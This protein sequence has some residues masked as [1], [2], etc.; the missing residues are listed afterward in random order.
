VLLFLLNLHYCLSLTVL[1]LAYILDYFKNRQLRKAPGR[2]SLISKVIFLDLRHYRRREVNSL[3]L[4]RKQTKSIHL[5]NHTYSSSR[6]NQPYTT[7]IMFYVRLGS[8]LKLSIAMPLPIPHHLEV[9]L[10]LSGP[11]DSKLSI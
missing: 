11:V 4:S 5:G 10:S 6:N 9:S 2:E 3:G 1:L 8:K 7:C